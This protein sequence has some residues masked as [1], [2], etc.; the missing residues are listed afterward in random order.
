MVTASR[1][2]DRALLEEQ[3]QRANYQILLEG[4]KGKEFMFKQFKT[5]ADVNAFMH[6]RKLKD[7]VTDEILRPIFQ[8]N[9]ESEDQRW[10]TIL[11]SIFWP[12]LERIDAR[13]SCWDSKEDERWSNITWAFLQTVCTLNISQ[14]PHRIAQKVLNDTLH[15]LYEAY[16]RQWVQ[17]ATE[18]PTDPWEIPESENGVEKSV[19]AEIEVQSEMKAAINS[20]RRYRNRNRISETDFCLLVG[21]RIYG[22]SLAESAR[23]LGISYEAAKKRRQ[24]AEVLIRK[25]DR[26]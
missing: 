11:L 18:C 13:K 19:L 26:K 1:A 10:R 17:A 15:R 9:R 6:P 14:R 3:V 22:K 24:R 21:T 20:Y 5:W 4:L 8:A 7:P 12:M 25:G 2:C 16:K 23:E